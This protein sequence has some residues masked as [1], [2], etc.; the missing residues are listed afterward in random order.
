M[1][2]RGRF[3]EAGWSCHGYI[4]R[5]YTKGLR[6]ITSLLNA[7]SACWMKARKAADVVEETCHSPS[8][9]A[10][11]DSQGCGKQDMVRARRGWFCHVVRAT[12]DAFNVLRY[13][14]FANSV[15][16]PT[17]MAA[18]PLEPRAPSS[19]SEASSTENEELFDYPRCRYHPSL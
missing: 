3:S 6:L 19:L 15:Q 7:L 2:N 12:F 4:A 16:P 10:R 17:A 13:G 9:S 1:A 14:F 18:S 5:E 11:G 8:A